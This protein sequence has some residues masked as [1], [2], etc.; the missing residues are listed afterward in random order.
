[1]IVDDKRDRHMFVKEEVKEEWDGVGKSISLVVMS[2]CNLLM[3]H[4]RL[5]Q[6]FTA[7]RPAVVG[8]FPIVDKYLFIYFIILLSFIAHMRHNK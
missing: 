5:V 3:S 2:I 6:D 7:Y 1:M 4:Y 8:S